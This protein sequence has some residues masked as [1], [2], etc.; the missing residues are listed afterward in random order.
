MIL[1]IPSESLCTGAV[2]FTQNFLNKS[3]CH[4]QPFPSTRYPAAMISSILEK[5]HRLPG[6][7]LSGAHVHRLRDQNSI[8]VIEQKEISLLAYRCVADLQ[9]D[10]NNPPD[11]FG[12]KF[13]LSP[14]PRKFWFCGATL[15][16]TSREI[17]ACLNVTHSSRGKY[18]NVLELYAT[19]HRFLL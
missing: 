17:R 8:L 7:W 18:G 4:G 6:D 1:R 10:A 2:L 19:H 3:V 9:T 14:V 5:F 16:A 11:P 12:S 15:K 13:C